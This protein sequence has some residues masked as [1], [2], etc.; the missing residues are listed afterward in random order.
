M[1]HRPP[2]RAPASD[3]KENLAVKFPHSFCTTFTKVVKPTSLSMG[4]PI[5]SFASTTLR[6]LVFPDTPVFRCT[7]PPTLL[8]ADLCSLH[9]T[10]VLPAFT[11][12][13]HLRAYTSF[14]LF[15]FRVHGSKEQNSNLPTL[16]FDCGLSVTGRTRSVCGSL[17]ED[18]EVN[19]AETVSEAEL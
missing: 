10:P 18:I 8:S 11:F 13:E 9:P 15:S 7:H 2:A 14:F 16:G 5:P 19:V 4:K 1:E 12:W 6:V 3:L 17:E